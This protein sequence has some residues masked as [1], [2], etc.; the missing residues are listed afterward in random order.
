M[1]TC[2][3]GPVQPL[4]SRSFP[5]VCPSHA[6]V[7]TCPSHD[8]LLTYPSR[9]SL[10]GIPSHVSSS[11]EIS[12]SPPADLFMV[13]RCPTSPHRSRSL[14]MSA[15]RTTL[16]A[17]PAPLASAPLALVPMTRMPPLPMTRT[18][19]LLTRTSQT[20]CC[21]WAGGGARWRAWRP[22]R[23]VARGVARGVVRGATVCGEGMRG[24]CQRLRPAR[25]WR[26]GR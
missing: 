20:R 14:W 6:S 17:L 8:F 25:R 26:Q 3:A 7:R 13:P 22:S 15:T 23:E 1:G 5:P 9:G 21:P 19:P 18:S 10:P 2:L 11:R 4:P 16:T 12:G 24:G